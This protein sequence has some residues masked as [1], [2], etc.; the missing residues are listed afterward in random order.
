LVACIMSGRPH[1]RP[2][3]TCLHGTNDI[4]TRGLICAR[5]QK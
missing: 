2:A 1:T 3:L 5:T 4:G